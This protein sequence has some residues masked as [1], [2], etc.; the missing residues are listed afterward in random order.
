MLSGLRWGRQEGGGVL[1]WPWQQA[2]SCGPVWKSVL[3]QV[4]GSGRATAR[5]LLQ[6]LLSSSYASLGALSEAT[7]PGKSS[8]IFQASSGPCDTLR[9]PCGW[10]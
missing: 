2:M 3:G 6:P 7:S 4:W 8:Q 1:A 9:L 5:P 10:S